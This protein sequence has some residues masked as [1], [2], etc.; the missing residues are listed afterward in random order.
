[1]RE[2]FKYVQVL[3]NISPI[4]TKTFS[5]LIPDNLKEKIEIGQ[6]LRVPFGRQKSINA[7]AVGFTNYLPENIKAKSILS[8]VDENPVFTLDYLKFL[9]WVSNYYATTLQ[10]VIEAAIPSILIKNS[11]KVKTEKVIVYQNSDGATK[12]QLEVLEFLKNNTD[13]EFTQTQ[14]IK[15]FKTTSSVIKKLEENKNIIFVEKELFRNSLKPFTDN[16]LEPLATLN[17]EQNFVY[18]KISEGM[19]KQVT[20]PYLIHGVTASGK[21]EIYFHL[22]KDT[23]DKGK[24]AIFLVPEIALASQLAHRLSKKFGTQEVALWHSSI[25]DGEKF[26]IIRKIRENK[27]KIIIGARSAIF[28]PLKNLGLII[29]D[30]E[31]ESSYKQ[32]GTNP[33][34]DARTLARQRAKEEGACL[35]LG[36]ATPD[37]NSY[38]EALNSNK[39]L[40]LTQRYNNAKLPKVDIVDMRFEAQKKNHSIFSNLLR[41]EINQ[42]LADKKQTILLVNRRGFSTSITCESCGYVLECPHCSIPLIYHKMTDSMRCHYCN[43]TVKPI[44]VCPECGAY[45]LKQYGIG[46]QKVEEYV[47]KDFPEARVAR[48]DS[49]IMNKKYLHIELL[50]KFSKGE[51]DILIGTQMIAK[52]LDNSNVTLVGVLMADQS[53]NLPDFRAQERGFQLLTQVAGRAGRGQTNGRVIFQSYAPD[54]YA[55]NNAKYQDYKAF[56]AKEIQNRY[57]FSYPPYSKLIRF[58]ISSKMQYRAEKIADEIAMRLRNLVDNNHL[59]ENVEILGASECIISKI[60][61]EYRFQILIK[62]TLGEKGHSLVINFIK[63]LKLLP[64][65]KFLVDVDPTEML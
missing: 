38:Y 41:N 50:E 7:F 4:D 32:T 23:L 11:Q 59:T 42:N 27:M 20:S 62:N 31:H 10:T 56:Y 49:D 64:D 52:G 48:I 9:E 14:L 5:Y 58:I 43:Y 39:L 51:I 47:R 22:I 13:K 34:Y 3:V 28:S 35:V 37:I 15:E 65:I 6:V 25:S 26:D 30:E 18:K 44:T 36:S 53:F 57:E 46:T 2:D 29:I 16:E 21:T 40:T 19:E 60:N 1:M 45:T 33:R 54:Y 17:D 63:Q 12:R 8:I 61:N 24:S 55:L